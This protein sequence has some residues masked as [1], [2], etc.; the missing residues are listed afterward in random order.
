MYPNTVQKMLRGLILHKNVFKSVEELSKASPP[1]LKKELLGL[2]KASN[3]IS[4]DIFF[5]QHGKEVGPKLIS[6]KKHHG[7]F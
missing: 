7:G 6:N 3:E 4:R 1:R 2:K 5:M